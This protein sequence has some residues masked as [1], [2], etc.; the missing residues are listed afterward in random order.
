MT[1]GW[2][3]AAALM[4]LASAAHGGVIRGRFQL[5]PPRAPTTMSGGQDVPSGLDQ[6]VVWVDSIPPSVAGFY[7]GARRRVRVVQSQRRFA[8][9]VITVIAGGTVQFVNRDKVYHNVFSVS[10]ARRFDIGKYAPRASHSVTF[11]TPGVVNL[12]CEIHPWMAGWVVVLPHRVYARPSRT[13]AFTLPWLP[14]GR[15]TVHVWHPRSGE[16][17]RVVNL[18]ERGETM[19]AQ[20]D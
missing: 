19:L 2:A 3:V 18:P 9:T 15:Y 13:G 20:G 10:P 5:Q 4:L 1:K 14:P 17:T 8:P 12:F 6:A 7:R 11:D 16:Q